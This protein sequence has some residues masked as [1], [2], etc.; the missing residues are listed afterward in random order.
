[1]R[2]LAIG[3]IHGCLRALTTLLNAVGPRPD[4]LIITLGDY[5]DR[6][7]DSKKVLDYLIDLHATGQLVALRGNHDQMMLD[8]RDGSDGRIW[9]ACGGQATLRSYSVATYLEYEFADIPDSHWDFLERR[10]VNWHET[11]THIYVHGGLLPQLPLERQP[12]DVLLWDKVFPE[13]AK[14]HCS[15]KVMICGHTRQASG[16]ILDLGHTLC[17]D[18]GAY[19]GGWLTCLEVETY[20]WWQANQ[21]GEVRHGHLASGGPE[22]P[23]RGA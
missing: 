9:L 18:T 17:I 15:G 21:G 1:M 23:E 12:V 8:A 14:P 6:G 22:P 19:G 3:D 16:D 11:D 4:D 7:P 20:R 10:C 5:V 2:T 13:H